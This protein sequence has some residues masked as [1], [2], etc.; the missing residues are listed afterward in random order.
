[1]HI[2]YVFATK[3]ELL[4]AGALVFLLEYLI[5]FLLGRK[6]KSVLSWP[7]LLVAIAWMLVAMWEVYCAEQGYNIRVDVLFIYPILILVSL[8][9]FLASVSSIILSLFGKRRK[10]DRV[11]DEMVRTFAK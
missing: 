4:F 6:F 1:M 5:V 10:F 7:L 8:L 11:F 9:G 3:P 2:G